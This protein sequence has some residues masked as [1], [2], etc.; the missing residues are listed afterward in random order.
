MSI[1]ETLKWILEA[2]PHDDV[3][4]LALADA[5]EEAGNA[6]AAA[7]H[8]LL[9]EGIIWTLD[10]K[11]AQ[12]IVEHAFDIGSIVGVSECRFEFR[13]EGDIKEFHHVVTSLRASGCEAKGLEEVVFK[14]IGLMDE[15]GM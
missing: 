15:L 11:L 1:I 8:R 10:R 6:K 13:H 4:R 2:Q 14:V 5:Y 12:E 3:A 7:V 9:L